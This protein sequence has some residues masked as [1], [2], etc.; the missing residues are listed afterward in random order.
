MISRRQFLWALICV[1]LLLT[2]MQFHMVAVGLPAIIREFDVPL[3]WAS[4]IVTIVTLSS[5]VALPIAG[6][7]V[8]ELGGSRVFVAALLLFV[9][10]SRLTSTS[11][12]SAGWGRG[13]PVVRF[14]QRRSGWPPPCSRTGESRRLA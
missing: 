6:K 7:L 8:D 12:S 1:P 3:R 9:V 2:S 14:K 5:A 10:A 11:S 4:W 13:S